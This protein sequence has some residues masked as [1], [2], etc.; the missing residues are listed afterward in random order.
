MENTLTFDDI[1]TLQQAVLYFNGYE[2]C[3]SLMM[4]LRWPDGNARCPHCGS[5]R[6]TYL[7][8][9]RVWK[10]YAKHQRPRFSLKTGTVF[11]DSPLGLDKWLAAVLRGQSRFSS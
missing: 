7:A 2:N 8:N 6:V 1:K 10:C 5:D 3:R 9:A 11:E 4:Q